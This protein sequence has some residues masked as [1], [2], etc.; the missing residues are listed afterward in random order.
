MSPNSLEMKS[1][2]LE[3]TTAAGRQ[4]GDGPVFEM[5]NQQA[6]S[7]AAERRREVASKTMREVRPFTGVGVRHAVGAALMAV[8]HRVAGEIPS[9][10]PGAQPTGDCF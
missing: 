7:V 9:V 6:L 5:M 8:G 4:T 1:L 10:R 2:G 3:T